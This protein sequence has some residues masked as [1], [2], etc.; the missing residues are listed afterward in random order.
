[1]Q[2]EYL[3]DAEWDKVGTLRM[4]YIPEGG[5]EE[6]WEHEDKWATIDITISDITRGLSI[7]V[8]EGYRHVPCGGAIGW[9]FEDYDSCVSE[10]ILQ[11]AVYGK[12]VWA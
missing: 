5:D 7:A 9:D 4:W 6:D 12:E 10:L 3:G 11:L 8:K 1:M 2:Y